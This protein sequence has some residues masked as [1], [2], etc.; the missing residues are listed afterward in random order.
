MV[1]IYP[2]RNGNMRL[3]RITLISKD[4]S[5][6]YRVACFSYNLLNI[7]VRQIDIINSNKAVIHYKKLRTDMKR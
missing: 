7:R 3:K 6:L 5:I 1:L 4:N 2:M